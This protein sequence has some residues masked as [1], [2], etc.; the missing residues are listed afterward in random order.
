MT[1]RSRA[2]VNAELV[3]DG[4]YQWQPHFHRHVNWQSNASRC[5]PAAVANA[6]R[7][8]GETASTERKVLAGTG[9]CWTGVC[10]LG[11]TLDE[12]AEVA[13][14]NTSRKV[15][16]LRDLNEEQFLEH[17]RRSNDP[18]RQSAAVCGATTWKCCG[19][20]IATQ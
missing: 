11:L 4:A 18:R 5:G 9:R 20:T 15:T 19:C 6:Y 7:S 16:V 10:I 8:L 3:F 14:T 17:L 2:T 1:E 12:L 13:R